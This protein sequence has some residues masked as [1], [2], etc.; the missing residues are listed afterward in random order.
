MCLLAI[1]IFSLGN[2]CANHLPTFLFYLVSSL[3]NSRNSLLVLETSLWGDIFYGCYIPSLWHVYTFSQHHFLFFFKS[4]W[5]VLFLSWWLLIIVFC[6]RKNLF[7][8]PIHKDDDLYVFCSESFKVLTFIIRPIIHLELI[9]V[10]K[11]WD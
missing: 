6:D 1:H 7:I 9:S 3:L 10:Y 4:G 5:S 11:G 2:V 8:P